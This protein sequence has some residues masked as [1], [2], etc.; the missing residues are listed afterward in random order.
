[1][2]NK[3]FFKYC[4][5]ITIYSLGIGTNS[6]KAQT[7]DRIETLAGLGVLEK[8]NGVAVADFDG[9]NDLDLFVVAKA[10]D[11]DG[12]VASHSRLFKNNNDG[13]FTDVTNNSGLVN[14]FPSTEEAATFDGLAGFKQGGFWGDYDNDGFPDLF[15]TNTSKVQLF[16]NEKNGTFIEVTEK[17]GLQKHN[18]CLN[19]GATWFD[20]N[21]DGLLDMYLSVWSET[22]NNRLYKNN[23][24]GTFS[25]VSNLFEGVNNKLS[26]QSVPYDFN[27][28]GWMDLYITNDY[29]SQTNDLYINNKGIGFTEQS[30]S[31]GLERSKDDMGIAIGDYNNDGFFDVFVTAIQENALF[32]NTDGKKFVNVAT[33]LGVNKSGWAWDVSFSDF[34]L[35]GDEDLFVVNGFAY[36]GSS[37]DNNKYFEN[38][39]ANGGNKF[40]D[41]SDKTK[42]GDLAVS[43]SEAVFDYDNDGDL[44]VLVTNNDKKSF[45]YE[46]KITDFTNPKTDLH[47]LKVELQG[48]VSNRD[49]IG[50]KVAIKTYKGSLYRYYS[51]VGFLS[52]SLKPIHFGLGSENKIIELKITWPS[53]LVEIYQNIPVDK[54][55]FVKEATGFEVLSIEPSKKVYGCTNP[56]SCNYNSYA[57][58]S[59]G[60][61]M[62][63]D[64]G[65]ISGSQNAVFHSIQI[66]SYPLA[67]NST[68]NW[69]VLGGQIVEGGIG[70]SIKVQWGTAS[71]GV[72]LLTEINS[73]CFSEKIALNVN[74]T[75][76]PV[77]VPELNLSVAR[78]WN[79]TLLAAIRKDYA[80]PTVHAR[81]LFHT[82]VAM[83]D[84]WAVFDNEAETYLLGKE[85]HGF[86]SLFNG[87]VPNEV[88]EN[89]R[90]K[91]ICYAV[92]RLLSFR[93][94]NS[95]DKIQTQKN[96]D[97]LMSKLGYDITITSTD[98]SLG[99]GADLGNYIAQTVID[100]GLVDGSN[101]INQ[102]KNIFYQPVNKALNLSSPDNTMFAIDPNR[103]QP[104]S[105]E[106]FIDQS[107]NLIPGSTPSFLGPEWGNVFPFS[108]SENDKKEYTRLGNKYMVYHDPGIPPILNLKEKTKSSEAYKWGFSLVSKWSSHLDTKDGVVWD[109]SPKSIGNIDSSKFPKNYAEYPNFYKENEGGDVGEGYS[110]NPYTKQPYVE[111]KVLRGD[112][113]RV[114]AEFWADGPNSET[115]PGHWFTI[116]NYVSDSKI[117]KKKFNGQGSILSNLE[118]D[119]KAYFVLGGA[120]HDC[121][122]SAWGIKGWF[123][124]IRPISAI[125]YMA[126]KGQSSD[127]S[128]A[129]YDIAGIPLERGHVE[130]VK[131]NDPLVGANKEYLGEIK[132]YC[133]KGHDYVK[134]PKDDEA[135]V[136]WI[137]ARNWW[138]YQRP[139]FVTPPFA[140]YI[141]GHST[142]S[143]A[144][145]EVMTL[146]TGDA[147]FPGGYGEFI[148]RRNEFLVFE[149]GPS[150]DVKLQWA[151][152]RDA[153]DQCSLS[154]IWGGIHPPG[155]DMPGRIIGEKIGK[156]VF[157]FSLQYFNG[158]INKIL[159]DDS[160]LKIFPN[161]VINKL[162]I[163][164][165]L[166]KSSKNIMLYDMHGKLIL[167]K[168]FSDAT[169]EINLE[170]LAKG[171]YLM[172]I[173]NK[174][175]NIN[176]LILKK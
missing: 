176:R 155:D 87:F 40:I 169:F 147:F 85:V 54:T 172:T 167:N 93:F 153:S 135:G 154:R 11:E 47:W 130:I 117:L 70:G 103:W 73:K 58:I 19:T 171:V 29:I 90:K 78:L 139:T 51:G 46:N 80:R 34:D 144:G 91:A 128:L 168:V 131:E 75:T 1:M 133:W 42:L 61:C 111:Q 121:A 18:G 146:L 62:M 126:N 81:N 12:V 132:L 95:P 66:Y 109:I 148:A 71:Q 65:I 157:D 26:Y 112:Y 45:F 2:L 17:A 173:F 114:L 23:G 32:A 89:S 30:S 69:E 140:G 3:S 35:D 6:I 151:T 110:I 20:Y 53:G 27:N 141:S 165:N 15:L 79:E 118:W 38:L 97:S 10:K 76:E 16:H 161:P 52:Q 39:Y 60:E 24:D 119:V 170:S 8:N 106:T 145:A 101:E 149:E 57:T 92:Y 43:V 164:T 127:A 50:A 63:L 159:I 72:V 56:T 100:Y 64:S 160:T 41:S 22:C 105:F 150:K 163:E 7:F 25:D 21:N 113:T 5:I 116:L 115:P 77:V 158:K 99:D 122:I 96:F 102:Y 125:R 120:M 68:A 55:I 136:G 37:S 129:N 156:E 83:Y 88:K 175:I 142:Y 31:F 152:Y 86:N 13:T 9:D 162:T 33:E 36:N 67:S 44:D 98:Y 108:L 138:P 4:F 166:E 28:D 14:L 49:A 104:L 107:G 134:D 82:S 48:T 74:L 84:A 59:S 123:D 137:L 94:I 143:R 124:Y 174:E